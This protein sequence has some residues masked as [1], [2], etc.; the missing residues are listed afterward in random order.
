MSATATRSHVPARRSL[1]NQKGS[2]PTSASYKSAAAVSATVDVEIRAR[3][4]A[5]RRRSSINPVDGGLYDWPVPLINAQLIKGI[6]E[7]IEDD[8]IVIESPP[9]LSL[10]AVMP[11]P[12]QWPF[13]ADTDERRARWTAMVTA[14]RTARNTIPQR[15]LDE[16]NRCRMSIIDRHLDVH[17]PPDRYATGDAEWQKTARACDAARRMLDRLDYDNR[18]SSLDVAVYEKMA[19]DAQ[20]LLVLIAERTE[21]LC[22][23]GCRV[24][25]YP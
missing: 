8:A 11:V 17:G 21:G 9:P 16:C 14:Q 18:A 1:R 5:Y 22:S 10:A 13:W 19:R 20:R 6:R 25:S 4:R 7:S 2:A 24:S 15:S 23:P 3:I 12:T